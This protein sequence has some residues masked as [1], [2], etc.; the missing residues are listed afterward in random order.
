MSLLG[1]A[2]CAGASVVVSAGAAAFAVTAF[3]VAALAA[4]FCFLVALPV[5][6]AFLVA[7]FLARGAAFGFV[8]AAVFFAGVFPARGVFE[9]DL[10]FVAVAFG[11]RAVFFPAFGRAAALRLALRA[12][13]ARP[14][15]ALLAALLRAGA[16]FLAVA[17][18]AAPLLAVAF[19]LASAFFA[20]LFLAVVFLAAVLRAVVLFAAVLPP[21]AGSP[22]FARFVGRL[23]AVR[24][25]CVF[26]AALLAGLRAAFFLGVLL[27]ERVAVPDPLRVRL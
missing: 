18:F 20:V 7:V 22:A 5:D 19:V 16:F 24:L 25:F 27:A 10:A 8:F 2:G 11:V 23:R 9:P 3:F 6:A 17:F 13:G 15:V 1:A 14:A 4:G 21:A 26:A 12:A